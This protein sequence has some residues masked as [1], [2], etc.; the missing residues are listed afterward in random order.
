MDSVFSTALVDGVDV[1]AV[2]AQG[3]AVGVG[4]E[5]GRFESR[6]EEV[7]GVRKEEDSR[8]KKEADSG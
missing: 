6:E 1:V 8:V 5:W 7:S 2:G 3:V 4:V